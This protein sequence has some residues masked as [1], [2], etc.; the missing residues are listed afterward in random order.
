MTTSEQ[1]RKGAFGA[2]SMPKSWV[3]GMGSDT[4]FLGG[5]LLLQHP[6]RLLLGRVENGAIRTR[7]VGL[8]KQRL[9]PPN[10]RKKSA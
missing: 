5:S 8:L 3:P 10:G 4:L 6:Y 1:F 2:A 9:V 7:G